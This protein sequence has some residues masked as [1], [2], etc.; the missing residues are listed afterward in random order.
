MSLNT[1]LYLAV[2]VISAWCPMLSCSNANGLAPNDAA[3]SVYAL[4]IK[5]SYADIR[6]F[7]ANILSDYDDCF[8]NDVYGLFNDSSM[9]VR[10]MALYATHAVDE[11]ADSIFAYHSVDLS[12]AMFN[13]IS[14]SGDTATV[15]ELMAAIKRRFD[16][17]DMDE[18]AHWIVATLPPYKIAQYLEDGDNVLVQRIMELLDQSGKDQFAATIKRTYN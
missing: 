17:M 8:R 5:G 16:A 18:K 2:I 6:T 10:A 14:E 4:A 1:Y 9:S 13:F 3:D 7:R 11:I 12:H 15:S